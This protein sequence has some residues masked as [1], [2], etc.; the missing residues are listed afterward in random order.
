[1]KTNQAKRI[2]ALLLTAALLFTLFG[3]GRAPQEEPSGAPKRLN[4]VCTLF[5]QYDFV[6]QIAGNKVELTLLL[7]PG[8]DS[9]TYDPS[10]NDMVKINNCDLFLYTGDLMELWAADIIK[11]IDKTKVTVLDL[12]EGITLSAVEHGEEEE[13]E[14]HEAEEHEHSVDPHIWT[15]PKNA[16]IMVQNIAAALEKLDPANANAYELDA[17]SYCDKLDRLDAQIREVVDSAPIKEIVVCDRFAMHYFCKEY[18]LKYI[19][20]FDSCT[21]E[22]E[23]SPAMLT[24][25]TEH[26]KKNHIPAVFYAELSNRNMATKVASLTGVQTLEL[27]SCHNVTDAQFNTGVTYLDLMEQNLNMLKLALGVVK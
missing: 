7:T 15:S 1:M 18:G 4:V 10:P 17:K 20:A 13:E 24:R 27:H 6:Q 8:A 19:A 5:P 14:E 16:A 11:S 21:S 22:T 23:P 2:F 25:I 26:V 9:H 12:S 3:C